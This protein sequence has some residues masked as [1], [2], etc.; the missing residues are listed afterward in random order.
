MLEKEFKYYLDNQE[1]LVEKYN[2]KHLVIVG[3]EV[4]GAYNDAMDALVESRKKYEQGTF[5]IQLCTPGEEAYTM[6]F[7]SRVTFA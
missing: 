6:T 4:I 3:H 1:E 7:H 2:G 5:L